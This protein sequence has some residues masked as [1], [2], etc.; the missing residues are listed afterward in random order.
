MNRRQFSKTATAGA[1]T[2][3]GWTATPSLL[4][5]P[6]WAEGQP[7]AVIAHR[8][9]SARAPEN[10]L[11]AIRQAIREGAPVVEFD[12][13]VT[14]DG[15]L[16]LFHDDTLE[17]V[18]GDG[19]SFATLT[20][21][22]VRLLDAGAWFGDGSFAG[23]SIPPL[24]EAIRLCIE[25]GV[26]PLIERKTGSA[27]SYAAR[28]RDLDVVGDVIVQAFDW[29]FLGELKRELPGLRL[30]ALGSG[31]LDEPRLERLRQLR[32][33]WIGWRHDDLP[34]GRIAPLTKEGFRIALWTVNDMSRVRELARDGASAIITDRPREAIETLHGMSE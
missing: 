23:E 15:A 3:P 1:F 24:D 34:G 14:R 30:G 26:T 32:P 17:K 5:S 31:E 28:I 18:C 11:V 13:R 25:Q 6:G 16:F 22:E 7:P 19:R 12:V 27:V 4:G 8:G 21:A 9:A 10:T 2:F 33:T 29:N 20:E